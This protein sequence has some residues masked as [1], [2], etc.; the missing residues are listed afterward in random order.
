MNN[1]LEQYNDRYRVDFY[2]RVGVTGLEPI[3]LRT[4]SLDASVVS[5]SEGSRMFSVGRYA[6]HDLTHFRANDSRNTITTKV[7]ES[8]EDDYYEVKLHFEFQNP[9]ANMLNLCES[10]DS[11]FVAVV[12][13]L[14]AD[15]KVAASRLVCPSNGCSAEVEITES[16]GVTSVDITIYSINGLQP[17][18]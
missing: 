16:E 14:G 3:Q 13:F 1:C 6:Q 8:K 17:L 4:R 12:R 9:T 5:I 18:L 2:A 10:L 15:G 7:E 11:S